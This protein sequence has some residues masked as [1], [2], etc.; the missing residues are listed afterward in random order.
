M[1]A[2]KHTII[3]SNT[4]TLFLT[5]ITVVL[6]SQHQDM[7]GTSGMIRKISSCHHPLTRYKLTNYHVIQSSGRLRP[8]EIVRSGSDGITPGIIITIAR[9]DDSK[10]FEFFDN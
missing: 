2:P 5:Y 1:H 9:G 4:V 10:D 3:M 6:V 8:P 7:A